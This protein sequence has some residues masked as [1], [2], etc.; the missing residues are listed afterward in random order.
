MI[1][2]TQREFQRAARGRI[3]DYIA[4]EWFVGD[5]RDGAV[6]MVS[7]NRVNLVES[8][9][10]AYGQEKLPALVRD[11]SHLEQVLGK[12]SEALYA[13]WIE[14]IKRHYLF[15]MPQVRDAT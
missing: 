10:Q 3:L 12:S 5:N 13:D 2:S 14:Y 6:L 15:P 1:Y 7:P 8:I 11:P 4:A 9:V